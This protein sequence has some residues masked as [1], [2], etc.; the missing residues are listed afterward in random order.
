[1]PQAGFL[2]FFF[3]ASVLLTGVYRHLAL[4]AHI[5][6]IPVSRS[7][8]SSPVPLGGGVVI[9]VL[10]LL[11]V[12]HYMNSGL[13]SFHQGIAM[14]AGLGVGIVGLLDD[15]NELKIS[16]RI[17]LQLLSAA[18]ALWWLGG[19]PAIKVLS[20]T[21]EPSWFLDVVGVVAL[22]WLLNLYNFMDGIDGIAGIELVFVN[23]M[24]LILVINKDS[25]SVVLLSQLLMVLAMGFLVWNWAPAKIFMGDVGSGFIGFTL[26]ILAII[27]MQQQSM[28]LWTWTILLGVFI[29][30]ATVTL[31]RRFIAGEKWYLG[32]ASHAYQKAAKRF[33]S[34]SKVSIVITMINFFWLA[35]LAWWSIKHPE[36]GMVSAL[37]AVVPLVMLAIWLKAGV[38]SD[39]IAAG[40]SK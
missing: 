27:S 37:V 8:H 14:F 1:M 34:H 36:L 3:I 38:S 33:N 31:V 10:Y 26:G 18:W 19:I 2:A 5:L 30:D 15:I 16:V 7:A 11:G 22:V 9:V 12:S 29:T 13:L 17:I 25:D 6:D 20:W 28:T 21:F 35:P 40:E 4:R 32:H 23:V 39:A 24:S